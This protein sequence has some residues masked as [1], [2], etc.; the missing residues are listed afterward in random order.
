MKDGAREFG[1]RSSEFGIKDEGTVR[2]IE[3]NEMRMQYLK[4]GRY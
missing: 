3:R 2:A 1:I 4:Q